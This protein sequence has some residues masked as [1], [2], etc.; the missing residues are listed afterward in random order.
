MQQMKKLGPLNKIIEM[1]PGA[2]KKELQGVD[3]SKS[4]K[5]MGKVEA[6]IKSM[7]ASER[8]H[9]SID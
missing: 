5:E 9:P 7:T 3:L 6:I 1:M 2:N 4:E 8:K